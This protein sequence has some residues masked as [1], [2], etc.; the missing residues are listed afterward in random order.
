MLENLLYRIEHITKEN[1]KYIP[2]S[3]NTKLTF[4]ILMVSRGLEPVANHKKE[5]GEI[6]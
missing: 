2:V 6:L 3:I 1:V 4:Q 5:L